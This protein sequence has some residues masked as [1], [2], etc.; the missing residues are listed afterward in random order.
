MEA[1]LAVAT[2]FLHL[3]GIVCGAWQWGHAA[4]LAAANE[5]AGNDPYFGAQIGL[6]EFYYGHVLPGAAGLAETVLASSTDSV[7]LRG[8]LA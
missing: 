1:A 8:L 6:A 3:A 5:A 7:D 2:P 4:E